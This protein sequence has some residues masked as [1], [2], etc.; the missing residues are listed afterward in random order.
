MSSQFGAGR[1]TLNDVAAR[2]GVSRTTAS[3]V[4][5]GKAQE[6]RIAEATRARVIEAA[7]ALDY[8]PNL[9]VHSMQAGRT[10]I[11]TFFSAFRHRF[12]GDLYMDRLSTA[13]EHAAGR[14][15]YN[16]LVYCD[17][18]VTPDVTYAF[19]NG[20]HADGL[21][22]FAPLPTDPLLPY[23]RSSRLPTVLV[24]A[25]D[26]EGVL[27]SV[28]DDAESGM[29]QVA[30]ALAERG[31][32]RIALL[33]QHG[34]DQRDS[35]PRAALLAD[36]MAQA[37][38]ETTVVDVPDGRPKEVVAAL[39]TLMSAPHPPTA[40]FCWHDRLAYTL[41]EACEDLGIAVPERLS[42]VGYD[43]LRWPAGTRHT[44]AS[45]VVDLDALADAAVDLLLGYIQG[46][47]AG[48]AA[49]LL[50]VRFDPGTSLAPALGSGPQAR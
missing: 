8:S 17:F 45:V 30:D 10:H 14:R 37:G 27:P 34:W 21:L 3:F 48:A 19:L 18:E 32:R 23:L 1:A 24:N 47:V 26:P 33:V 16:V 15:G 11:L 42:V 29:R 49:T 46:R 38:A 6:H 41:L 4:L 50:P 22:F 43:G 35:T 40:V 7:I 31:H 12:P 20:G 13:V 36:R 9:L 44:A 25:Q 5:A 39:S 2:A 28:R